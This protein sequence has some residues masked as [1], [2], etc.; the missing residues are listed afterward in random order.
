MNKFNLS[1]LSAAFC[2][3]ISGSAIGA[4]PTKAEYK[5]AKTEISANYAADKNGCNVLAGN[6]KDV[7]IEEAKGLENVAR[8]ELEERYY[9]SEKNSYNVRLAKAESTYAVAKEKCDNASGNVKDVCFKEAKANYV[10]VKADAKVAEKTANANAAAREET[11]DAD[12]AAAGKTAIA[13]KDAATE[14]R[15]AEY[16]LAKEKCDALAGNTKSACLKEATSLY[17]QP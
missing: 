15:L 7:C 10:T 6:A 3:A 9:P 2:L 4:T 8:A 12:A 16:S 11:A 1:L 14:K 5:S 13:R 17:G